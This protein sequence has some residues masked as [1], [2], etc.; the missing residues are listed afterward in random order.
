MSIIKK[1]KEKY[2]K[3]WFEKFSE[4]VVFSDIAIGVTKDNTLLILK[5]NGH[6]KWNKVD[7]TKAT[8]EEQRKL[9]RVSDLLTKTVSPKESVLD[10]P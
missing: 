1:F 6:G 8:W 5:Y 3:K 9:K 4:Y 2:Y 10:G 7:E